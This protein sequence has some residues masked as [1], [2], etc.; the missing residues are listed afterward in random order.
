MGCCWNF[1][2]F[3]SN[4]IRPIPSLISGNPETI[5]MQLYSLSTEYYKSHF[6]HSRIFFSLCSLSLVG[7]F[8]ALLKGAYFSQTIME[9]F[10]QENLVATIVFLGISSLWF[11]TCIR[12][13]NC[14]D[15]IKLNQ[16][17]DDEYQANL[18]SFISQNG[19]MEIE[20]IGDMTIYELNHA[21]K[22]CHIEVNIPSI[23]R[24]DT[25]SLM[26]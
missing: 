4:N 7:S 22:H 18:K 3:N 21:L 12:L 5:M 14:Q 20:N 6:I 15:N 9:L 16:I 13:E 17:A 10:D 8:G 25:P 24:N 11:M 1:N 2:L 23:T 19:Q 26:V